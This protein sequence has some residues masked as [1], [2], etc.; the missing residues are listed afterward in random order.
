MCLDGRDKAAFLLG[1]L[2]CLLQAFWLGARPATFYVVYTVETLALLTL[3]FVLYRRK[4]WH[5]FL[6]DI[7]YWRGIPEGRGGL[8]RV[9][10]EAGA[11][12]KGGGA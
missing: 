12:R 3:R 7:C 9:R 11:R 4:G 10:N 1:V 5:L 8:G 6:T 2:L